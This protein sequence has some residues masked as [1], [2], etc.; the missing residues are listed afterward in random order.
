MRWKALSIALLLILFLQCGED[1]T[2]SG[3]AQ[4][5]GTPVAAEMYEFRSAEEAAE[6]RQSYIFEPSPAVVLERL[7]PRFI[8]MQIYE[9]ILE[10]AASE[11]SARMVAMK[12]A[13]DNASDIQREL[14]LTYNKLRQEQITTELLDIVGGASALEG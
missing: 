10:S 8:E 12:N 7:L 14:T 4:S 1:S 11:Q 13:T 6:F 3:N 5:D 2:N 9:A